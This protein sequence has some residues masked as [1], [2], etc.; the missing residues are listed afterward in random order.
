M[1]CYKKTLNRMHV[2]IA[3]VSNAGAIG[4]CMRSLPILFCKIVLHDL[5]NCGYHQTVYTFP[6]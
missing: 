3:N 6:K 4:K 1:L 5:F 2:C